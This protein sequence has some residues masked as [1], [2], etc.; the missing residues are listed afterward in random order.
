M[1]LL[2]AFGE[3]GSAF[4]KI[5][6]ARALRGTLAGKPREL[7]SVLPLSDASGL[8]RAAD[9]TTGRDLLDAYGVTRKGDDSPW[10]AVRMITVRLPQLLLATK[11]ISLPR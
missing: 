4:D 5:T 3:V 10:S 7:L 1:G 6:G 11:S 9:L 2:E 8:T